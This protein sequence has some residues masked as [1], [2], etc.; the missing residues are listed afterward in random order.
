[1][2]CLFNL[3]K[4]KKNNTTHLKYITKIVNEIGVVGRQDVIKETV[5]G[6]I[7]NWVINNHNDMDDVQRMQFSDCTDVL[8]AEYPSLEEKKNEIK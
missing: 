1:M 6:L 2:H 7:K 4:N 5:S 3:E 8:I